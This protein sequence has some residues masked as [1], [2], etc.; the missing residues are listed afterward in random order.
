MGLGLAFGCVGGGTRGRA[1]CVRSTEAG[2]LKELGASEREGRA[3]LEVERTFSMT[4]R[5]LSAFLPW[6]LL[7]GALV[8]AAG[9]GFGHAPGGRFALELLGLLGA[10]VLATLATVFVAALLATLRTRAGSPRSAWA[11]SDIATGRSSVKS[12]AGLAL[13]G[14]AAYL[15]LEL[16]EGHASLGGGLR[17]L[18]ASVPVAALVALLSCRAERAAGR[19]GT[20]CAAAL[21]PADRPASIRPIVLPERRPSF[22]LRRVTARARRGRAPPHF[23]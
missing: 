7:V 23:V 1:G 17:A 8:H 15:A 14:T 4:L 2:P 12:I 16:L 3:G 21:G 19:A 11:P 9:S 18:L 5:K 20:A 13:A 6:A 10:T 22:P